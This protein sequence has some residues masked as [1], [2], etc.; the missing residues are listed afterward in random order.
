VVHDSVDPAGLLSSIRNALKPDGTYLMLEMNVSNRPEDN[1][2]PLGRMMYSA[3]TLYCMT[4]SLAHG[5]AGI[6]ALMGEDKAR[7][8]A[9]GASFTRF[10]RLPVKDA[11]STLYE[12]RR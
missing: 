8:L 7:E 1:I 3:S 9:A 10:R 6:G 4:V 2:N 5:G 11:F 12:V